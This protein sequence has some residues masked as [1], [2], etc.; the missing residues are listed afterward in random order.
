MKNYL[1][2]IVNNKRT[3]LLWVLVALLSLGQ[4]QR[5]ELSY[6]SSVIAFYLHDV[7]IITWIIHFIFTQFK[8]FTKIKFTLNLEL[9][10]ILITL[11]SLIFNLVVLFDLIQVLYVIRLSA[12]LLFAISLIHLQKEKQID[13][14]ILRF[15]FFCVGIFVLL[16]GFLQYTFIADTRF[17]AIFGWDDHYARMISTYFDPGFTGMSLVISLLLGLSLPL[18]ASKTFIHTLT[19]S[20]FSLGV[21]LTFSRA[22]YLAL[23]VCLTLCLLTNQVEQLKSFKP[24]LVGGVFA[25]LLFFTVILVP[26]PFGEGVNLLRTSTIFARTSAISQQ[27]N[28]TTLSTF[29]IGNGPFSQH[30]S[31]ATN[32]EKKLLPSHSRVP[33]SL[34]IMVFSSVGIV[35]LGVFLALLRKW[36]TYLYIHDRYLFAALCGLVV[37]AQFSNSLLQPFVLL[38]FLGGVATIQKITT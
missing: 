10:F 20:L 14:T 23:I 13:R 17:L 3:Y 9:T 36:L 28:Q 19:V 4:L 33:D 18:R 32:E 12:Y 35:G 30:S 31:I 11:V 5:V 16:L 27:L 7:F 1:Q 21:I 25:S 37:H 29:L 22:S 38:L 2:K 24:W 8:F 26:K 6:H 34:F 15:Q